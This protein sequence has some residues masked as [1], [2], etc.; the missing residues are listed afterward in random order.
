MVT[1]PLSMPAQGVKGI[2]I[3]KAEAGG[4][5]SSPYSGSQEVYAYPGQWWEADVTLKPASLSAAGAIEGFIGLLR[6]T[7]GTFLMGDPM[8]PTPL[9]MAASSPGTPVVN[10]AQS[11]GANTLNIKGA[12]ASKTKYLAAGDYIQ[13]GSGLNTHLHQVL[14]DA[15]TD[16]SGNATLTLWPNLRAAVA[17]ND[18]VV[19]TACM[20]LFRMAQSKQAITRRPGPFTD[21]GFTAMEAI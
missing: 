11:A 20:G 8:R 3:R 16:G 14:Q 18:T 1:Y 17:D 4:I 6:G 9:G 12:G 2:V 21:Y 10:G 13:L 5:T 15:N 7:Y 19:V